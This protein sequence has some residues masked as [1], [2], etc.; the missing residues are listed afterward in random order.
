MIKLTDNITPTNGKTTK[1]MISEITGSA[2]L[3][4]VVFK[5]FIPDRSQ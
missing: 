2:F 3:A 4:P 1:E 5:S